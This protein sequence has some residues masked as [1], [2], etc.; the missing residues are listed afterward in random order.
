ME[1]K[2][3]FYEVYCKMPILSGTENEAVLKMFEWLVE[4]KLDKN[5]DF[6][7]K[8]QEKKDNGQI[9]VEHWG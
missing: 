9:P 8:R 5:K 1:E 2:Q 4:G 3:K 7:A 6:G